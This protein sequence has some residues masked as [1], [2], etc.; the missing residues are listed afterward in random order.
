MAAILP[1]KRVLNKRKKEQ[2]LFFS[3]TIADTHRQPREFSQ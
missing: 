2:L 1:K 3:R